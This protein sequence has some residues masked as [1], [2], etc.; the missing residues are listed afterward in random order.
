MQKYVIG[1]LVVVV[2]VLWHNWVYPQEKTAFGSAY[3]ASFLTGLTIM[4]LYALRAVL[5]W[6]CDDFD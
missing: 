5:N 2:W 3:I 1:A 4:L 6:L